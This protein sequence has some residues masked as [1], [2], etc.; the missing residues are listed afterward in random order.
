M[1]RPLGHS[2]ASTKP[3]PDT[4]VGFPER[5]GRRS[6]ASGGEPGWRWKDLLSSMPENED[7]PAPKRGRRSRK[8][9]DSSSES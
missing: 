7:A 5:G 3:R 1:K 4:A 2:E 9:D 8:D 6:N